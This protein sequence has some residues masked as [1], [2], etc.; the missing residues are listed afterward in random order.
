MLDAD[1]VHC[2]GQ[3]R[4][5]GIV[6]RLKLVRYIPLLVSARLATLRTRGTIGGSGDAN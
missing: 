5:C 1:T 6:I 2:E 4:I 3:Q